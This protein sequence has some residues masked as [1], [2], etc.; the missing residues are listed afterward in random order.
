MAFRIIEPDNPFPDDV[1]ELTSIISGR[2]RISTVNSKIPIPAKQLPVHRTVQKVPVKVDPLAVHVPDFMKP[3]RFSFSLGIG[4]YLDTKFDFAIM[5]FIAVRMILVGVLIGFGWMLSG[6]FFGPV[7]GRFTGFLAVVFY[8]W[9]VGFFMAMLG[10]IIAY[11]TIRT[12][13]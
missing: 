11:D 2:T 1:D 12:F 10:M 8:Q 9:G 4:K 7:S 6:S 3:S 5:K 13:Y